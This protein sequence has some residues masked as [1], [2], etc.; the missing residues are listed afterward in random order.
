MVFKLF[1]SS[2][3]SGSKGTASG[4]ATGTGIALQTFLCDH[5]PLLPLYVLGQLGHL[6]SPSI[7]ASGFAILF[8]CLPN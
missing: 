3:K 6:N 8:L 1:I 2:R 7:T 4:I 5:N